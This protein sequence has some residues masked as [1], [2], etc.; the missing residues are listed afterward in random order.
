MDFDVI[1]VNGKVIDGAGNPWF[2]ADVGVKGDEVEAVG[3]L[4]GSEAGRIIDAGGLV[5][6]PGFIDIHSHSDYNVII[7]PRVESKVRQ[8]VTTEVVGNCGSSAA[9]M[10]ADVRAYRDRYM[11]AR[12]G[13]DFDFSWESME[14][15]LD[16][17]DATGASF[18]VV[19]LVGQGT[20]RQNVMGYEDREPTKSELEEMKGLVSGAMEN[21]AWGM[22]TGLIYTPST[23]A[24]TP[25]IVEL[26]KVLGG[27]N[28]VYFSHIR[29]EGETLLAAV[30]EAVQIGKEAGVPVQIAHFKASGKPH[31]GKTEDSLRLVTEGREAGVDVTFDQYPYIASSTGLAAYMPHWSQEG[32]ADRLLERLKNPEIREKIRE[33]RS[34]IYRTWDMIL[35]ASAK[36]HP[37][38]EGKRI[39]EIAKL[40]GKDEY[41]TVFELLL[42][43]DAQVSVVSFGMSEEDVRRVMRSPH[44]MVGSDGSAAAPWGILGRGKPHPRF[45]GTFP[46]VIG[47]YVREG[48][49][50]L[51]EAV[52][53]MTSAPA[54]RLG[55]GDRGLLRVGFKADITVF[56]PGKVKDEATFVDPHRF[57]SGIPYVMVN[58]EF[59]VDSGEHTGV[60]PG[61]TLRKNR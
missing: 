44:G 12:L 36:N 21:G 39:S 11:R 53:K 37:E 5:V 33:D 40:E 46:R 38:Y 16:I 27:Y 19:P 4:S 10:N 22:S 26:A 35:V 32:G 47:H 59:V 2:K 20:V 7:D 51:Q 50:S 34:G 17:I 13:D 23:Y 30:N 49:L 60:L 1:Y 31:W 55:L 43:E 56:D 29:G 54:Q 6:A 3:R 48:V 25:E 58:G 28:G 15:Y 14:D 61:R 45:Y 9:P 41:E 52:R 42:A 18:N 8:G 57:A 24:G